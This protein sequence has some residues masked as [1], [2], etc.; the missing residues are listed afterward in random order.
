MSF[1]RW[2]DK[3]TGVHVYDGRSLNARKTWAISCKDLEEPQSEGSQSEQAIY[4][5]YGSSYMTFRE[6]KICKDSKK[7]I[8]HQ[9]CKR[10]KRGIWIDKHRGFLWKWKHPVWKWNDR[11]VIIHLRKPMECTAP[12]VQCGFFTVTNIHTAFTRDVNWG[13]N[14]C[15]GARSMRNLCTFLSISMWT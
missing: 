13:E 10:G 3:Y 8:G 4:T 14:A 7:I 5:P 9:G 15:A 12:R 11:H 2:P 1:C 6:R